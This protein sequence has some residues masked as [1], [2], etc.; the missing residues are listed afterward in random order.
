MLLLVKCNR[1]FQIG[2][3]AGNIRNRDK[4]DRVYVKRTSSAHKYMWI[5][6]LSRSVQCILTI[7]SLLFENILPAY[8]KAKERWSQ[9]IHSYYRRA[10]CGTPTRPDVHDFALISATP[11]RWW[12]RHCHWRMWSPFAVCRTTRAAKQKS[13][14][15]TV[16]LTDTKWL[17]PTTW[18]HAQSMSGCL[19]AH[20]DTATLYKRKPALHQDE[21]WSV[22][23][24]SWSYEELKKLS[25]SR[26]R[27]MKHE[28]DIKHQAGIVHQAVDALFRLDATN[29][30][31]I[32][33]LDDLP[34]QCIVDCEGETLVVRP[35]RNLVFELEDE[36]VFAIFPAAVD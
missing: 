1:L 23:I 22:K 11:S 26:L 6:L 12:V 18:H 27:V 13:S 16:L 3:A 36:N 35:D 33:I 5:A 14:T 21:P 10:R 31:S 2:F 29:C 34:I 28:F 25:C 30:K 24:D 32:S 20:L 8:R 7:R 17:R 15:G 4:S 9:I 19:V